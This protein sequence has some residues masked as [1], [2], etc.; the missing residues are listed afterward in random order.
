MEPFRLEE[1]A[2]DPAA[3]LDRFTRATQGAGAIVSFTGLARAENA[4]GATLDRLELDWYPG[5]TERS[6]QDIGADALARFDIAAATIVHRCGVVPVREPIVFVAAASAHR[7]EA[8][9]AADYM[10]D[11]LKTEAVFW[12]KE[13]GPDGAQWIEPTDRDHDDRS[14]WSK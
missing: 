2:I 12:K 4:A 1:R 10:M 11:R 6:I 5:M 13:V 14:R 7:R 3:E 9:R 8:F